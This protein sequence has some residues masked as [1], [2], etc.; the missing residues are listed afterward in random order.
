MTEDELGSFFGG[1][2]AGLVLSTIICIFV[3]GPIV[4]EAAFIEGQK[5]C[6]PIEKTT[7]QEESNE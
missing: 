6:E 4:E 7:E 2:I 3:I 1:V 5:N